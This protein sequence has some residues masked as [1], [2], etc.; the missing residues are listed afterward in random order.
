ME[1]LTPI[2]TQTKKSKHK[3]Q[4]TLLIKPKKAEPMGLVIKKGLLVL[5]GYDKDP[6]FS[7][8]GALYF[9]TETQKPHYFDGH[10]WKELG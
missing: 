7:P 3:N 9:N 8:P 4:Q 10:E 1:T 2:K 6:Q 5:P